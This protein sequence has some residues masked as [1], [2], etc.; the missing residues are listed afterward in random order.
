MVYRA[1][2]IYTEIAE[3]DLNKLDMA[4]VTVYTFVYLHQS[5]L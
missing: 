2:N 4:L 5:S 3:L 1:Q